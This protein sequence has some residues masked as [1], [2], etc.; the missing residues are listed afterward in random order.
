MDTEEAAA[1]DG[2]VSTGRAPAELP[3]TLES[4]TS[5]FDLLPTTP[6]GQ[7]P[8]VIELGDKLKVFHDSQAESGHRRTKNNPSDRCPFLFFGRDQ[9][10][11]QHVGA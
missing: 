5:K 3:T 10:I 6:D 9:N 7:H 4:I 11:I 8:A 1:H 2:L